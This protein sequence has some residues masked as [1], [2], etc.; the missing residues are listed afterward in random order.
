MKLKIAICDDEE[1]QRKYVLQLLET[2]AKLGR[3]LLEVT[4]FPNAES[5]LFHYE[6]VKDFD[7]LLLD[8]E[9]EKL[10]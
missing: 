3:H 6:T 4:E 2:W 9:M 1:K 8:V 5:F 7:I 10:S